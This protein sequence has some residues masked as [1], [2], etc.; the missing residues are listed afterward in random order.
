MEIYLDQISKTY[1]KKQVLFDINMKLTKGI[2]GLLGKNGAGKTTLMEIIST[3][4]VPN[5][6]SI[7]YDGSE[8][9]RKNSKVIRR[10]IG[11]LAQDAELYPNLSVRENLTYMAMLNNLEDETAVTNIINI[12]HLNDFCDK[13]F[14][15]L[16]G[17]MKRRTCLA[18]AMMHSPELLIVDEPTVGVDPE[19][20][21]A[22]RK[23]LYEYAEES[24]V[25]FSTHIIEDITNTCENLFVLDEGKILYSGTVTELINRA[26][27]NV[28]EYL[29]KDKNEYEKINVEYEVVVAT[30]L[31]Q[32]IKVKFFAENSKIGK[33]VEEPTLE[34]AYMLLTGGRL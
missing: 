6:G 3:L 9:N 5:R 24:L 32:G 21:V 16:S 10:K 34:D 2:Y 15:S 25:L 33:L 22:I 17:G 7:L 18:E 30:H 12:L 19:E 29:C 23:I 1:G 14:R 26:H 4:S 31:Q 8:I 20:R 28:Y 13:K 11:Y 27:G